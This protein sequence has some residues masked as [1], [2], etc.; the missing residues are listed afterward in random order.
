M[1]VVMS[2]HPLVITD[3]LWQP[4]APMLPRRATDRCVAARDNRRLF[5]KAAL[6]K[7]GAGAHW[8][9]LPDGFSQWR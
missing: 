5:L 1:A 2:E 4:I 9:D 3:P 8:R 7:V 6:W